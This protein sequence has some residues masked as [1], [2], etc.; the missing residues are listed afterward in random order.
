[1][2]A[3]RRAIVATALAAGVSFA[4]LA[5]AL[6]LVVLAG[7]GPPSLAGAVLAANIGAYSLG[8]LLALGWRRPE[9]ALS[10]GM[11]AVA[12]GGLACALGP[13]L[14][15]PA[16]G[17]V[18]QGMGMG[19]FWVGT[20]SA[21]GRRA[22]AAGSA[23]AFAA[24][25]ALYVAGTIVGGTLTAAL[26]GGLRLGGGGAEASLRASFLLGTAAALA[27]L[28]SLA[29][30]G[31]Q[32][33]GLA[34]R[35]VQLLRPAPLHS[36]LLQLPDF[37]LVAG[38]SAVGGLAPVVL[39]QHFH[40]SPSLVSLAVTALAAAKAAGS[41]VGG[42]LA[43]AVGHRMTAAS[44]LAGAA[45][46][47]F[48]LIAVGDG[49]VFTAL[50]ALTTFLGAGAWPLCVDGALARVEWEERLALPVAWNLREPAVMAAATL[51][52]GYLLDIGDGRLL[53]L[54]VS[55]ALFAAASGAVLAV[56]RRPLHAPR[57]A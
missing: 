17:G 22:G 24:Q 16:A 9:A 52:G 36:L 18:V 1:M 15:G 14:A 13:G 21:L 10:A 57:R 26:I 45:L 31:A 30:G 39:R 54:L 19:L 32:E 6:P 20:Q 7:G 50:L 47:A 35:P 55:G 51:A 29:G 3:G 25:Y 53:L 43:G 27:G 23:S 38:L 42:R 8:A 2:T 34:G 33:A 40:L 49:A 56:F 5:V 37:L 11:A 46:A 48:S 41:L 44:M 4:N 12:A 28:A